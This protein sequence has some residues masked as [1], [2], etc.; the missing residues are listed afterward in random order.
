MDF[1]IHKAIHFNKL[2]DEFFC[3][4]LNM[5]QNVW[6]CPRKK[7]TVWRQR[8]QLVEWFI[9]MNSQHTS[10]P[11]DKTSSW[12]FLE[13]CLRLTWRNHSV[14]NP[15]RHE[16]VSSYSSDDSNHCHVDTR[17]AQLR[18]KRAMVNV[19]WIPSHRLIFL[20]RWFC[21]LKLTRPDQRR[22]PKL[23]FRAFDTSCKGRGIICKHWIVV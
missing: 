10:L 7:K 5:E 21:D 20:W 23:T 11:R 6:L 3:R 16:R 13:F 8:S 2:N 15:W 17:Q 19:G 4:K 14:F 9:H 1:W 22:K 18:S 12:E